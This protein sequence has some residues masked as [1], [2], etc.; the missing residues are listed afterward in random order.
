MVAMISTRDCFGEM[1]ESTRDG[2]YVCC[3]Q[4]GFRRGGSYH[5]FLSLEKWL[6]RGR[7]ENDL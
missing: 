5:R 3:R 2:F 6:R 4:N 7:V 1:D